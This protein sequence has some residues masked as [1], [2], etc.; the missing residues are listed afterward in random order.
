MSLAN[1]RNV[2][3]ATQA[4]ID[5]LDDDFNFA[6]AGEPLGL[7]TLI[8]GTAEGRERCGCGRSFTGLLSTMGTSYAVVRPIPPGAFAFLEASFHRTQHVRSWTSSR[9]SEDYVAAVLWPEVAEISRLLGDQ[10]EGTEVRVEATVT[11]FTLLLPNGMR[12]C[13]GRPPQ[14]RTLI[15]EAV[16]NTQHNHSRRLT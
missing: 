1:H 3:V 10:F 11:T 16:N 4:S 8:C 13:G 9:L 7:P 5:R 2:L 6:S 12:R 15:A 14:I